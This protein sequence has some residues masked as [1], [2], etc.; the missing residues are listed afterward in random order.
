VQL[1]QEAALRDAAESPQKARR[2]LQAL[3]RLRDAL[4]VEQQPLDAAPAEAQLE[5]RLRAAPEAA[6][7]VR[8]EVRQEASLL[9][10]ALPDAWEAQLL[11]SA[12]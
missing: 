2:A 7:A 11:P 10:E 4:L 5:S 3:R 1:R 6:W 9:L 12:A 8:P